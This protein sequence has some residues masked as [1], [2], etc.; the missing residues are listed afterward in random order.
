MKTTLLSIALQLLL[1]PAVAQ[2]KTIDISGDNSSNDYIS[3]DQAIS[4]PADRTV[5]VKMAR[6]C[7]FTSY[8]AGTG[9]LNLLAGGER[10]YLGTKSGAAW[11]DWTKFRGDLHIY[12]FKENSSKAGFY[13]VVMAHGGKSFS[14]ENIEDAIRSGKVHNS[15][16][17]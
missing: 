14:P 12:P 3:Y 4:L 7:Y 17:K 10:C 13:G 11:P 8:I 5:E 6:Y 15:M 2:T 16:E 9:T 1:L